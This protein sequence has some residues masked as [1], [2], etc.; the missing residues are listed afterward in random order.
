MADYIYMMESRLTPEQQKAVA[1]IAEAARAHEM[2]IFLTG[3][4]VRDEQ[5]AEYS[6]RFATTTAGFDGRASG[7]QQGGAISVPD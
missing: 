2:N 3:G 7:R 5:P 4:A 1:V 6:H